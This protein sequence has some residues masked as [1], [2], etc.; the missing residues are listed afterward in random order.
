MQADQSNS[1]N[2]AGTDGA[3]PSNNQGGLIKNYQ[4]GGQ[5]MNY[6]QGGLPSLA[7]RYGL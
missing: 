3:S 7:N 2:D 4:Y 1:G 6:A 5:V